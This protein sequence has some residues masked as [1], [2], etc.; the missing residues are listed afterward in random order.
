MDY[1]AWG[2]G[3]PSHRGTPAPRDAETAA[4]SSIPSR[5]V[6][7]AGIWEGFFEAIWQHPSMNGLSVDGPVVPPPP[8]RCQRSVAGDGPPS[9]QRTLG[10]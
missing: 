3:P 1:T 2:A 4:R 6:K 5:G 7:F 9:A 10:G 8:S